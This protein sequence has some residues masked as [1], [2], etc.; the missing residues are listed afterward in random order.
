M[1]EA[2]V[3]ALCRLCP[4]SLPLLVQ[5]LQS[6]NV[7]RRRA[8][9]RTLCYLG[10]E[11]RPAS[12]ALEK[13]LGDD[14][15]LVRSWAR[16]AVV[17]FDPRGA[18]TSP[19][20]IRACG[21]RTAMIRQYAIRDLTRP[22]IRE[23]AE[24]AA[25]ERAEAMRPRLLKGL[26]DPSIPARRWAAMELER[27]G[28]GAAAAPLVTAL[29]D[30]DVGVRGL[31]ASAL[32]AIGPDGA[33]AT[34]A[35]IRAL[36]DTSPEVRWR[37][38]QALGGI[39]PRAREAIPALLAALKDEW[40]WMRANVAAALWAV[41]RR[42]ADV[43]PTLVG[44]L[45]GDTSSSWDLTDE[46]T[47]L[48]GG[49]RDPRQK[50]L[51]VLSEIGPEA[52]A[53]VPLL[54]EQPDHEKGLES[55][56]RTVN[57]LGSIGPGAGGAVAAILQELKARHTSDDGSLH[58]AC[59][60]AMAQIGPEARSAVAFIADRL[61]EEPAYAW[62]A[63]MAQ[64]LEKIGPDARAA[65]PT[66]RLTMRTSRY[67]AR[68]QAALAL[69]RIDHQVVEVVSVLA[70]E[71]RTGE[72]DP[73]GEKSSIPWSDR[74]RLGAAQAL[75]ELGKDSEPAIPALIEAL[76]DPLSSVRAW[77]ADALGRNGAKAG[78]AVPA[79]TRR[80]EDH[81]PSVRHWAATALG[82]IGRDSLQA[83][84]ALRRTMEDRAA[85]VRVQA[86]L[87]LWRIEHAADP[88]T[89]VLIEA[90]RDPDAWI[91]LMAAAAL[92]EFGEAGRAAVPMLG[93]A[94]NDDFVEVRRAAIDALKAAGRAAREVRPDIVKAR[95]D[96][97]DHVREVASRILAE[98]DRDARNAVL[99]STAR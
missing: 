18:G 48:P 30:E 86:A 66:L 24:I 80:L 81:G 55:C 77:A 40:P 85:R 63:L 16:Q 8:S 3:W 64:T 44:L 51:Q 32:G 53:A 65:L 84:P 5:G 41:D 10:P 75:A 95:E 22:L 19:A 52:A 60:S 49:S 59:Y 54:I 89:A 28:S 13:A 74:A 98:L 90:L 96:R 34:R 71:L 46:R 26:G 15:P 39:G 62:K 87:A 56:I 57:V 45:R 35:L 67:D 23:R 72:A 27:H 93:M 11:A 21:G 4:D 69:W 79:L 33:C 17:A 2:G 97:D 58:A 88:S 43:L 78:A 1:R 82:Q 20:L 94:L 25:R 83:V 9:A 36:G 68:V 37:A 73:P 38:A 31:A 61:T 92:S 12:K 70:D 99:P 91:R 7:G 42:G 29:A 50:A 76:G 6:P 14:D 47:G